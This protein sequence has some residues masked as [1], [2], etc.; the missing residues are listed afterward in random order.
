MWALLAYPG[1]LIESTQVLALARSVLSAL[2]F[3]RG[4][5]VL[6]EPPDVSRG[7]GRLDG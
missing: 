6:P 2:G 4:K 1:I 5:P 3:L 7:L